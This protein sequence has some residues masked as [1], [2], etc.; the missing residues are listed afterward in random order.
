MKVVLRNTKKETDS[1]YHCIWLLYD[2]LES[3]LTYFL[4]NET[5]GI[6]LGNMIASKVC[7]QSFIPSSTVIALVK[8]EIS[9]LD[10]QSLASQERLLHGVH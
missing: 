2:L 1:S 4:S 3:V 7:D 10:V 6:Y 9:G 5:V 8:T